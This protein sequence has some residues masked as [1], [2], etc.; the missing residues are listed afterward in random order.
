[1]SCARPGFEFGMVRWGARW[2]SKCWPVQGSSTHSYNQQ[3]WSAL[4]SKRILQL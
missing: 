1:M 4:L 2:S 3:A